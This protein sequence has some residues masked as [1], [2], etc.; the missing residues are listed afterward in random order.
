M[1]TQSDSPVG[2]IAGSA[3]AVVVCMVIVIIM[4]VI[5]L[6][7]Y[8]SLVDSSAL[9]HHYNISSK[10]NLTAIKTMACKNTSYYAGSRNSIVASLANVSNQWLIVIMVSL[11]SMCNSFQLFRIVSHRCLEQLQYFFAQTFGIDLCI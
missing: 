7:R 1:N 3:V 2:I 6:R 4:V 9:P 5:F 8:V 11:K 10:I